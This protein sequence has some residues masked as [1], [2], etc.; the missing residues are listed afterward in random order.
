L[1]N[2]FDFDFEAARMAAGG[3]H[4]IDLLAEKEGVIRS[5]NSEKILLKFSFWISYS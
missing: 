4:V 1:L 3:R 2:G 5:V